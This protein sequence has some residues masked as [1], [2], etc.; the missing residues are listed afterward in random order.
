MRKFAKHVAVRTYAAAVDFARPAPLI[1]SCS[2]S[3]ISFVMSLPF[4]SVC[5]SITAFLFFSYAALCDFAFLSSSP[6][7]S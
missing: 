4:S 5:L 2:L 1:A 3:S 7:A 6:Q